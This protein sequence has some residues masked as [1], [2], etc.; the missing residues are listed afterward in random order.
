MWHISGVAFHA[1]PLGEHLP[2]ASLI[3]LGR[4]WDAMVWAIRA[5][6]E[7]TTLKPKLLRIPRIQSPTFSKGR[8]LHYPVHCAG[9]VAISAGG[10]RTGGING[11]VYAN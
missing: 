3:P 4:L 6:R 11:Q 7:S 1:L 2:E 9:L 8:E 5:I 10:Y